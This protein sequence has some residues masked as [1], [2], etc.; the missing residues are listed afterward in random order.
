MPPRSRAGFLVKGTGHRG[1]IGRDSPI[2]LAPMPW[3]LQPHQRVGSGSRSS[4]ASLG[5]VITEACR[6]WHSRPSRPLAPTPSGRTGDMRCASYQR[7]DALL[8][9]LIAGPI[10]KAEISASWRSR[11]SPR[12]EI[13]PTF[14]ALG[15]AVSI[16]LRRSIRLRMRRA[17]RY[18]RRS[19]NEKRRSYERN[20]HEHVRGGTSG[21]CPV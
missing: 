12:A 8:P 1:R 15:T 20:L 16:A 14:P 5:G 18:R 7:P 2:H 6:L 13:L 9:V 4:V 3:C 19:L 11:F 10:V 21:V 17:A